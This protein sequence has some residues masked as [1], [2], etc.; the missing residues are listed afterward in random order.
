MID[1]DTIQVKAMPYTE[2]DDM[3]VI[4]AAALVLGARSLQRVEYEMHKDMIEDDMRNEIMYK[5]SHDPERDGMLRTCLQLL[6][7]V[8]H[9]VP[10]THPSYEAMILMIKSNP[11]EVE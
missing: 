10:E 9:A 7:D 6:L 1:K 3:V 11:K 2:D 5:M 8:R 4:R